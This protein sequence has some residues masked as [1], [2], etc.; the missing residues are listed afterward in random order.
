MSLDKQTIASITKEWLVM[1]GYLQERPFDENAPLELDSFAY[2][3]FIVQLEDKLHV[4]MR[5]DLF[6]E[7]DLDEEDETFASLCERVQ[8]SICLQ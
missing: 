5:A 3:S 7:H 1:Q 8:R 2:L 6:F 4:E